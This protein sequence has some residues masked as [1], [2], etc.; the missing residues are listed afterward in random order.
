MTKKEL[1]NKFMQ[2][3]KI[4]D[5]LDYCKAPRFSPDGEDIE[6]SHELS[7]EKEDFNYDD[8]DGR[9]SNP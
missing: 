4:S 9:Y 2:T 6:F 5:Y 3:G 7:P 8:K 1:W